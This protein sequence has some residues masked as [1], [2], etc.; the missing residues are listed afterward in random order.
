MKQYSYI[1][2]DLD[3][4]L[5]NTYR[6]IFNCYCYAAEQL[7]LPLPTDKMV[8]EVIG[9]PLAEV[10][11]TRFALDNERIQEAISLYRKR[12]AAEGIYEMESYAQMTEVLEQLKTDGKILGVATLK[13][14]IFAKKMLMATGLDQYMN[15]IVGMDEGD[16]RTKADM[17][18]KAIKRMK[19]N[20]EETVLVGDS[21]YDAVGAEIAGVDFV[22]VTY[23]FGFKKAEE[24]RMHKAQYVAAKPIDLLSYFWGGGST[25]GE[26]K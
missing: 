9:A 22:A 23:G 11:R 6:G 12:Y 14:E 1:L 25:G 10:F 13:N 21:L 4:T 18:M 17:I 24:G 19:G 2:F 7:Q 5:I 16:K 20:T 8:N 15:V 3:G 26:G